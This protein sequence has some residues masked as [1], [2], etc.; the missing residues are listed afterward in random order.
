MTEGG[1]LTHRGVTPGVRFPFSHHLKTNSVSSSSNKKLFEPLTML[2]WSL[3]LAPGVQV[4]CVRAY[5][6]IVGVREPG[7][8]AGCHR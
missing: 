6:C 3:V 5:C 1:N 2:A 8:R 4:A 7:R